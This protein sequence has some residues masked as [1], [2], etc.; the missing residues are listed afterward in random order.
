MIR[1]AAEGQECQ[2]RIPGVCKG[3]PAT[4]VLAHLNGAGMAM[5]V[6]DF[7]GAHCCFD[8]HAVIDGQRESEFSPDELK[9]FH[10]EGIIRTQQINF[11]DGLIKTPGSL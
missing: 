2:V 9:L 6:A 10:L 1:L 5:K 3:N 11:D 8:C 7:Q 4:T